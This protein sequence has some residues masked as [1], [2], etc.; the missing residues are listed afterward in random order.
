M[1]KSAVEYLLGP[2]KHLADAQKRLDKSVESLLKLLEDNKLI[3][4]EKKNGASKGV[5]DQPT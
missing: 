3:L 5:S 4:Q 2:P 1:I